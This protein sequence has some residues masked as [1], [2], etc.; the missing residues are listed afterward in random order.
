MTVSRPILLA[1]LMALLSGTVWGFYWLPVREIA[2]TG[3]AGPWGSVAIVAAAVLLL[4]PFA[5]RRRHAL[6][7]VDPLGLASIA[8]GGFSFF[9]YSVSFL[10]GQVAVVVILFFLTP[11]W[12]TVLGRI[13]MGWPITRM[14]MFVLTFG[15][16]GLVIML[17][18]EGQLPVPRNLGEWMGLTSGILWSIASLG[19]RV[20]GT[21][22]P[23]LGSFVFATGALVGGAI[24][25]LLLGPLPELEAVSEPLKLVIWV[26]LAGGIWWALILAGLMWAAPKLEPART[27]IL[28][29]VEVP[30]AAVSAAL[31]AGEHLTGAEV[32]GGAI[33]VLAGV[34]EVWPT[35]R[36]QHITT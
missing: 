16:A 12:S 35:R 15:L 6:R 22:P 26:L 28:L 34:M 2:A 3:F 29:M 33:V 24:I 19:I 23:V 31:I 11:V 21:P 10:Y 5:W 13:L 17:G 18:A 27:G 1:P 32:F 36:P 4:S 14:R 9:L 30:L 20:R 7:G 8:L 25:A